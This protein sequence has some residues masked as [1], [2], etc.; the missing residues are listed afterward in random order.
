MLKRFFFSLCLLSTLNL[1]AEEVRTPEEIQGELQ[2]AQKDFDTAQKIFIPWYTGPLITGSANNVPMGHVNL[3]G[4]L[5]TTVNYAVF[6]KNRK[7]VGIPNQW[8]LNPSLLFQ[9]GI[10]PRLDITV[11]P[12]G[13]F[14]WQKG[15]NANEWG[16]TTVQFGIQI[17]REK[18]YIPSIRLLV[19][20]IFPTGKYRRLSHH[21][22]G[23]DSTGAGAYR[24]LF[25][26]N[27]SKI[28][29]W[30]PLHP[31]SL[32]F[33]SN[34]IFADNRAPVNGLNSYGGGFHT[35]GK[36]W[37]GNSLNLDIGY[38]VSINQKWVFS[39]DIAY[40]YSNKSTFRGNPGV[41]STGAAAIVGAP[42]SDQL[43]LAPAIEYNL[44]QSGGFI[45]G[46]WFSM[47]GRNAFNFVS[48]VLSYTQY[49]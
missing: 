34:Y 4:Y 47:T 5:F 2:S 8:V 30:S 15:R 3:Q 36:V 35:N 21:R 29:W 14:K 11:S 10:A 12:Q 1:L 37:V 20:E 43:S 6:N 17:I 24:T 45:G 23:L 49:F 32:R 19:G 26:L 27:L 48:L 44:H 39:T 7:S 18:P 41:T 9:V 22:G 46:V 16:D 38:E 25:G 28:F 31:M 42:S 33:S 40:T 13:F